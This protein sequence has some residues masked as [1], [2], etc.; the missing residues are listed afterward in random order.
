MKENRSSVS[1]TLDLKVCWSL[2]TT[3]WGI[4]S[5]LIQVTVVPTL[6]VSA[7]GPKTKL[8][9]RMVGLAGAAAGAETAGPAA[10]AAA[11]CRG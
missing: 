1:M 10:T 6:T 8:S 3:V 5:W 4:S 2:D 11:R 7:S 9:I